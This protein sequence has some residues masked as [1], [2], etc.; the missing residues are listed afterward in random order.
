MNIIESESSRRQGQVLIRNSDEFHRWKFN[1][2]LQFLTLRASSTKSNVNRHGIIA[3]CGSK[4]SLRSR[5]F[6]RFYS[7]AS[8]SRSVDWSHHESRRNPAKENEKI[9]PQHPRSSVPYF[10]SNMLSTRRTIAYN[11]R[12]FFIRSANKFLRNLRY[13]KRTRG[14]MIDSSFGILHAGIRVTLTLH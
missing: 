4:P 7:V 12:I 10:R 1:E 2:S 9:F 6:L 5:L 3:R 8:E 14:R 13:L 11:K